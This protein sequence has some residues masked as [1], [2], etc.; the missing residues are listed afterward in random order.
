M[1]TGG[2]ILAV[3]SNSARKNYGQYALTSKDVFFNLPA[4]KKAKVR[5][6]PIMWTDHVEYGVLYPYEDALVIKATVAGKEFQRI[7]WTQVARS[8]YFL[9]RP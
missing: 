5:Q 8:I 1:I 4:A 2:P 6:V 9:S 7:L 3:D